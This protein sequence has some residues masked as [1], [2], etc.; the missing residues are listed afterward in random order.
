MKESWKNIN[1]KPYQKS[2]K[3]SNLGWV[4]SISRTYIDSKGR[5]IHRSGKLLTIKN[6]RNNEYVSLSSH[7]KYKMFPLYRLVAKTFVPN[8][9]N[10]PISYHKNENIKDNRASNIGWCTQEFR[11]H[12]RHYRDISRKSH[13]LKEGKHIILTK[14]N[15]TY[16]FT[17]VMAAARWIKHKGLHMKVQKIRDTLRACCRSK[18][19][20]ILNYKAQYSS[21]KSK[22]ELK[23]T[24]IVL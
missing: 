9:Y 17:S 19:R 18:N 21:K 8:P 3:V 22:R 14:D 12:Y 4:R 16:K 23:K 10:Y 13:S 2:Y 24:R 7:D 11:H 15:Q 6:K 1:L 20:T 5:T